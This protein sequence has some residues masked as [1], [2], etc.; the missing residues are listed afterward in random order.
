MLEP[1]MVLQMHDRD[2]DLPGMIIDQRLQPAGKRFSRLRDAGRRRQQNGTPD[3][4]Q[5]K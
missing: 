4:Q 3:S 1:F 5:A 2:S